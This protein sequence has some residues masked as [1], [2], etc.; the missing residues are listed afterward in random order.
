MRAAAVGLAVLGALATWAGAPP[1]PAAADSK[2]DQL[3]QAKA[4]Q[5]A[6]LQVMAQLGSGLAGAMSAQ[7]QI[8][9]SLQ[10][11]DKEQLAVSAQI[12]TA[13]ARITRLDGELSRLAGHVQATQ[14]HIAAERAELRELAR[15]IYVQPSSLLLMVAE[16]PNLGALLTG[17][18]DLRSAG[19]RASTLKVQLDA[20]VRSLDHQLLLRRQDRE[21]QAAQRNTLSAALGKLQDLRRQ[22]A[23]SS[24]RLAEKISQT[25]TELGS[26]KHQSADLAK[27]VAELL[28]QQQDQII[29]AAM[30]QVWTQVQLSERANPGA[31]LQISAQHSRQFRFIWPL[32]TAVITQPFGPT[33]EP[34]EPPFDGYP[35]FHTG[36]DIAAP[37]GTPVMAADDGVVV[38]VGSS[39]F[40]YGNYVVLGHPGGLATLYGHLEQSLVKVGQTVSQGQPIGLEGSTGNSTGPHCHFELR[41]A[42]QPVD[43][44]PYLPP[45]PPSAFRG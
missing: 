10:E 23:D 35:H 14:A 29:A 37:I 13:T 32:A 6:M 36:I 9:R 2:S 16:A 30:E 22:Q 25:Q 19:A 43:P 5:A 34:M 38:L 41:I 1:T 27:R 40:G 17:V 4:Q 18:M 33:G 20:D 8:E 45:G 42:G 26:V 31:P 15:A 12:A 44:A 21:E 7:Q 3:A 24:A 39:H 11:N 28:Q